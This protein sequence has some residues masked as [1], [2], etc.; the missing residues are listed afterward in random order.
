[1]AALVRVYP[2]WAMFSHHL[3]Q[4]AFTSICNRLGNKVAVPDVG[5]CLVRALQQ[6]MDVVILNLISCVCFDSLTPSAKRRIILHV[7][8]R[9]E[10]IDC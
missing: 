10:T 4:L 6:G 3:Y 5:A 9:V 8:W 7:M 1:M 2:F